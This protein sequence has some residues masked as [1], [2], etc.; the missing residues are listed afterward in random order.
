MRARLQ[1]ASANEV[2]AIPIAKMQGANISPINVMLRETKPLPAD[3]KFS[4]TLPKTMTVLEIEDRVDS[5]NIDDSY[6]DDYAFEVDWLL[7]T[8]DTSTNPVT[9]VSQVRLGEEGSFGDLYAL[10]LSGFKDDST[11]LDLGDV[12]SDGT[13]ATKTTVM[14]EKTSLSSDSIKTLAR[15]DDVM[16][17]RTPV[18][19]VHGRLFEA[20]IG[21]SGSELLG[22]SVLP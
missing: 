18:V 13:A 17:A 10:P 16:Q 22:V 3:G 7:V 19:R 8:V 15:A 5:I 11:S 6:P 4:F 1:A 14:T 9:V 2:W 20:R 21:R 12:G